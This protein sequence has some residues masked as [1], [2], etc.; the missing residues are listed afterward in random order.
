MRRRAVWA[1]ASADAGP[2]LDRRRA[3]TWE[4]LPLSVKTTKSA[5]Q[6]RSISFSA[7]VIRNGIGSQLADGI[8]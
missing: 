4:K 1:A 8:K 7:S 2:A 3:A 5:S 6:L